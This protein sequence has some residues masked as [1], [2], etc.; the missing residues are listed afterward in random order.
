MKRLLSGNEAVAHGAWAAGAAVASG[1]PGTPSTE[2]LEVF[3]K[4][5]NVY[6]EWA[7]NEKAG[8]DAAVG[9][10]YAGKRAFSTMKHVGLNVAADSYFMSSMTGAEAGLVIVSADDPSMHSLCSTHALFPR[11]VIVSKRDCSI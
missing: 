8:V 2:I 3:A 9:A 11:P 1:Y 5:P 4:L 7:P 6:A 10:A